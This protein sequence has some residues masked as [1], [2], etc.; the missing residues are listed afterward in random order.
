MGLTITQTE[1]MTGGSRSRLKK[2]YKKLAELG[3]IW[4]LDTA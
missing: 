1:I 3:A 2:G 4:E